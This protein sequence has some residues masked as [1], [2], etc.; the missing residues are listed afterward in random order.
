MYS[1]Y[2][3]LDC[4]CHFSNP[5]QYIEKHGLDSPPYEVINGCPRCGG[6]YEETLRCDC[7]GDTI[8]GEY[9]NI[10][11]GNLYCDRCF[12]IKCFGAGR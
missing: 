9:V 3:C 5:E 6:A 1:K 7:C 2:T 12:T 10:D 4:Y 11:N 8:R